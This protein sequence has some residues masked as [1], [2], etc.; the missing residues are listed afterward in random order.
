MT[1]QGHHTNYYSPAN[2]YPNN[3]YSSL[4]KEKNARLGKI[5]YR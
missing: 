5:F 2:Q 4:V 1:P 3:N